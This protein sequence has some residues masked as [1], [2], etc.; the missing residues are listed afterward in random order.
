RTIAPL[1]CAQ[2]LSR[3]ER[4]LAVRLDPALRHQ[5]AGR[6]GLLKLDA[7]VVEGLQR[8]RGARDGAADEV[9]ALQDLEIGRAVDQS[10]LHTPRHAAQASNPAFRAASS[11][12]RPMKTARLQRHSFSPQG[13]WRS[14]S[15]I[16]CTAWNST[17]LSSPATSMIRLARS[18]FWPSS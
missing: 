15:R 8:D 6:I 18:M 17:R 7:P 3:R 1:S 13:F 4:V 9:A 16:M 14:P 10:G 11:R 5:F 2:A 12:S